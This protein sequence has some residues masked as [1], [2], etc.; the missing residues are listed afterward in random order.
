MKTPTIMLL[1]LTALLAIRCDNQT[2]EFS[3]NSNYLVFGHFFG[4]C[5]G[6]AC[7]E[8]FKIENGVVYEDTLDM[9]PIQ[10]K[11]PHVTDFVQLSDND[12]QQV[13]SLTDNIPEKLFDESDLVIGQ[14]DAGDWGGYYVE[15]NV[16]G[17]PRYW[18][19]DKMESNLPAYLHDFAADLNEAIQKLQPEN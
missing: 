10:S 5:F 2:A 19:I 15:T 17:T 13:R 4:E 18:L 9:Y 1:T 11:L 8:I 3:R 12:Y 14:P 7:V 6:E 16:S